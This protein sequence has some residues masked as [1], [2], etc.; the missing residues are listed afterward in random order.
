MKK[1][2]DEIV[3]ELSEEIDT[4]LEVDVMNALSIQIDDKLLLQMQFDD[5][6]DQLLLALTIGEVPPGKFREKVLLHALKANGIFPNVGS[7]GYREET[8][9]LILCDFIP[10]EDLSGKKLAEHLGGFIDTAQ[11]WDKALSS[12]DLGGLLPKSK[13]NKE[14]NP[15]NLK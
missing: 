5:Y 8:N 9:E 6:K 10:F 2:F 13:T 1:T 14:E 7:F 15:F 3:R 4:P 11:E 12:G